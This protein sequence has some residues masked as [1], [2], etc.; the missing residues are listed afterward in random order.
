MKKNRD[1]EKAEEG[2]GRIRQKHG[3]VGGVLR[4]KMANV[5]QARGRLA[6]VQFAMAMLEKGVIVAVGEDAA[7]VQSPDNTML[8][9]Q[10][11]RQRRVRAPRA[12]DEDGNPVTDETEEGEEMETEEDYEETGTVGLR[13]ELEQ[14]K[15]EN[16]KLR[17]HLAD[18]D[19]RCTTAVHLLQQAQEVLETRMDD[20]ST[21]DFKLQSME[22]EKEPPV[23]LENASTAQGSPEGSAQHSPS[24]NPVLGEIPPGPLSA[25]PSLLAQPRTEVKQ[26]PVYAGALSPPPNRMASWPRYE[27]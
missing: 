13:E 18:A 2:I 15:E 16:Q 4:E 10:Q 22:M 26:I 11:Q 21:M 17:E 25:L 7:P 14:L 6:H 9:P 24:A 5:G 3:K 1:G 8:N 20:M 27:N 12:V 19:K 23:D